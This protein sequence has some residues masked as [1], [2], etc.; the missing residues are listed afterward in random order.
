MN[1]KYEIATLVLWLISILTTMWFVGDAG[2]FS[3]LVP[4]YFMCM[5]G[6]I[7]V[8]KWAKQS[9]SGEK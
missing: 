2:I 8:V 4:V 6:S 1:L 5:L 7:M 9:P 3:F